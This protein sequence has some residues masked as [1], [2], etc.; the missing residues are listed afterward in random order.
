MKNYTNLTK[1]YSLDNEKKLEEGKLGSRNANYVKTAIIGRVNK[2][3]KY[4]D[5]Y[6]CDN[7]LS[8][9]SRIVCYT[10]EDLTI[11]ITK[12]LPNFDIDEVDYS[13]LSCVLIY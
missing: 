5:I 9:I 8:I 12:L 4:L 11:C 3:I 1:V 7:S 10:L 13:T 6:T 2:S